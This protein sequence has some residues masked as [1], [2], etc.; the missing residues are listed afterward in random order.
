MSRNVVFDASKS[1]VALDASYFPLYFPSYARRRN[2]SSVGLYSIETCV[3][4][5]ET[6]LSLLKLLGQM[7]NNKSDSL[8][9]VPRTPQLTPATR[10]Y[11]STS[12]SL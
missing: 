1:L 2:T 6:E 10:P 9:Q 7:V 12:P 8:P 3:C 4:A 11:Q 5:K